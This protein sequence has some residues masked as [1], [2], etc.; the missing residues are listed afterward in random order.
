[1]RLHP[2][3]NKARSSCHKSLI[4][5]AL[6]AISASLRI[7]QINARQ[8][9]NPNCVARRFALFEILRLYLV[10]LRV[11]CFYLQQDREAL[12]KASLNVWIRGDE[13]KHGWHIGWQQ[14][15][16]GNFGCVLLNQPRTLPP[17]SRL[18]SGFRT[19]RSGIVFLSNQINRA[20]SA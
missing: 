1:M 9:N 20:S 3:G 14:I 12:S 7:A 18:L 15:Q 19:I 13:K 17:D 4:R 11:P 5:L 6:F 10:Q 2:S 8:L 16:V